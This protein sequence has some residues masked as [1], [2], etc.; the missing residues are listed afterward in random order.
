MYVILE[1]E[2]KVRETGKPF[3]PGDLA[4]LSHKPKGKQTRTEKHRGTLNSTILSSF[5]NLRKIL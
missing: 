1:R 5:Q 2:R 4:G 3:S